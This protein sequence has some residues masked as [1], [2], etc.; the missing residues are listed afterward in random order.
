MKKI[1][2]PLA[3]LVESIARP[4]PGRLSDD[5]L[6]YVRGILPPHPYETDSIPLI[7]LFMTIQTPFLAAILTPNSYQCSWGRALIVAV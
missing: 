1:A 6:E 5:D 4:W 3:R 7:V 2:L